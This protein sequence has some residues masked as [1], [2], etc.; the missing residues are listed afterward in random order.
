MFKLGHRS[1]TFDC[2]F[3]KHLSHAREANLNTS[4]LRGEKQ[5]CLFIPTSINVHFPQTDISFIVTS[6]V[7]LN[8]AALS[9]TFTSKVWNNN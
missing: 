9:V 6:Q 3:E 1:P 7:K 4:G 2:D 8:K 5:R